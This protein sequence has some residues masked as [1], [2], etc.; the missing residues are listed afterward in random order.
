MASV[1][2]NTRLGSQYSL[3]TLIDYSIHG[4]FQCGGKRASFMFLWMTC[5]SSLQTIMASASRQ[6]FAFSRD[7]GT[8]YAD[9]LARVCRLQK[10]ISQHELT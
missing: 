5:L 10:F 4:R 2:Y 7:R 1:G 3:M 8:P 9:W 6:M